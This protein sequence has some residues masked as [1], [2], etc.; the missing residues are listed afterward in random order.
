MVPPFLYVRSLN[1]HLEYWCKGKYGNDQTRTLAQLTAFDNL[2]TSILV[3]RVSKKIRT[4]ASLFIVASFLS[5][6]HRDLKAGSTRDGHHM[7]SFSNV[8]HPLPN[9][10]D[11]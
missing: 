5:A 6:S 4:S 10:V 7:F 1:R 2:N 3:I 11:C 8:E 9:F